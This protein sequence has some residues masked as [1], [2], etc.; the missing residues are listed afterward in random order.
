MKK[1]SLPGISVE[2][3]FSSVLVSLPDAA[4]IIDLSG[5]IINLNDRYASLFGKK[6]SACLGRSLDDLLE[7]L[8]AA[9]RILFGKKMREQVVRTRMP[10]VFE[11]SGPEQIVKV[12]I[13]PIQLEQ[14]KPDY[15]MIDIQDI[16]A[17][18]HTDDTL[19][20]SR[21]RFSLAMD[22]ANAGVWEANLTTGK[23]V[24]SDNIWQLYGLQKGDK[25]ATTEL[26]RSTI[27]PDDR[28]L[29][30]KTVE[31]AVVHGQKIQIEYRVCH[32]D[33]TVR[34]LVVQGAPLRG[35][36][37][38]ELSSYLGVAADITERRM[39][40]LE[41]I[42]YRRHMDYAL[43]KSHVGIFDLNLADA[44][45]KR[46]AEHD[47]IF[48][49]EGMTGEWSLEKFLGHVIPEDR[50]KIEQLHRVSMQER[51]DFSH[52]CRIRRLDGAIRWI[53]G[54]A[55]FFT[56][57]ISD[58]IH[59]LGIVQDI[60]RRKE[61]EAEMEK[62]QAQLLQSQKLEVLGQVAGG[63]AHDFNNH[64]SSILGYAELALN[65]AGS[66][67][68]LHDY[69]T[70]I[71]EA[72]LR[73]SEL[74]RQLLAFARKQPLKPKVLDLDQEISK[75]LPM[76]KRL[77]DGKIQ[78]EFCSGAQRSIISIDPSQ[79]V[80]ILTNLCINARDA[81]TGSGRITMDTGVLHVDRIDCAEGEPCQ[82]PGEYVRLSVTDTG[83]G[84]DKETLPHIFEPFFTTKAVGNGTGLGLATVYGIVKQ[85][86]GAIECQSETGKG[87]TFTIYFPL[88]REQATEGQFLMPSTEQSAAST[89]QKTILVV[90][91]EAGVLN[92]VR[93]I[94]EKQG[95][96]VIT[97]PEGK[98]ALETA[99]GY[100]GGVDLLITDVR[101]PKMN[102]LTLSQLLSADFPGMKTLFLSAFTDW[103]NHI[104]TSF[105]E[106]A[107]H[108]SKPI[109]VKALLEAVHRSLCITLDAADDG[110]T[111]NKNTNM[112]AHS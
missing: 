63:I 106:S 86:G 72:A 42:K 60:T 112:K 61:S 8:L 102:G 58:E 45:A 11:E 31:D 24:W 50:E 93:H 79:L 77:V 7:N 28:D 53:A 75:L 44:S 26:W 38:G 71:H 39:A 96:V 13:A 99:K 68:E 91:D 10:V 41:E 85:H 105:A 94:L 109:T 103:K 16:T 36:S 12:S 15:L 33:S 83:S 56:D 69:L 95:Y 29:V 87:T 76:I 5:R 46:T 30:M 90:D 35:V 18:K 2:F 73:S 54:Q 14:D 78:F 3:V 55:F 66:S 92:L 1:T 104:N 43:E 100:P 107:N 32:P 9:D 80:Q 101:L 89:R 19:S 23:N 88:H 111:K 84:I 21:E 27:H 98:T 70:F 64:L 74:T 110:M 34:W 52:E 25:P 82:H 47:R 65:Q 49:Y 20:M 81:I 97:A 4:C 22:L 59:V 17:N 40:E 108:L 6:V 57:Q 51:K 48:G 62:L 67:L 37:S